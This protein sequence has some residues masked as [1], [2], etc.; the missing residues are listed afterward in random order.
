M[1]KIVMNP[2]LGQ[3]EQRMKYSL[4]ADSCCDMT[5]ELRSK[6]EL[7][8]VP[9]TVNIGS[10]S[11]VDDETLDLADM[12]KKMKAEEG[13]IGSAC[14]SP[15]LFKDAFLKARNCFAV[16]ISANLSGTYQ[17]AMLGKSMAEEAGADVHVFDSKSACAG[18]VLLVH[19]LHHLINEG[20]HKTQIIS[21]A[22]DF[23]KK[24]KTYFVLDNLDNLVKNGRMNKI[25][26]KLAN[27]LGIKPLLGADCDGNI[28]F[29]SYSRSEKQTIEKLTETI[30]KSGKSTE[31]E[32]LVISHCNNPNLAE[33]LKNTI[34]NRFRFL[35]IVI[36]PTGG[37][38]TVYA[39]DKGI[40][41]AF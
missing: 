29:F 38:S 24:M 27:I 5:P 14:P 1:G 26:G 12:M 30:E 18:E 25:A 16:T 9:L 39:N 2:F 10:G 15:A 31:G 32:S 34:V 40:V 35:N 28:A 23:I 17:S 33:K 8:S 21:Q 41:I 6:M 22:D 3:E 13:H 7:V 36:V 37:I 19:K 11:Y 4:I 20:L